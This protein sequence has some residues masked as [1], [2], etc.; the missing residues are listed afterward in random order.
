MAMLLIV[1][2]IP[3]ATIVD[4]IPPTII[5]SAVHPT[6]HV[7]AT[8]IANALLC[9]TWGRIA[10][11]ERV[12]AR[13]G[14]IDRHP[15]RPMRAI[16]KASTPVAGSCMWEGRD[17]WGKVIRTVWLRM[18]SVRGGVVGS[19]FPVLQVTPTAPPSGPCKRLARIGC[20]TQALA[21]V[22]IGVEMVTEAAALVRHKAALNPHAVHLH[23]RRC[24]R[25]WRCLPAIA[26]CPA[27]TVVVVGGAPRSP[28]VDARAPRVCATLVPKRKSAL[29]PMSIATARERHL[30]EW[31]TTLANGIAARYV[32]TAC[33]LML[34]STSVVVLLPSA[35][36]PPP[37]FGAICVARSIVRVETVDEHFATAANK[38]VILVGPRGDVAC[39]GELL[40]AL[41]GGS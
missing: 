33:H 18:C 40:H 29:L 38:T 27:P 4:T 23:R 26:A 6:R 5:A 7:V 39:V 30:V 3:L 9:L 8:M 17:L 20:H 34:D 24:W 41:L 1:M 28:V 12:V 2:P 36:A 14:P 15:R 16:A 13:E 32:L 35:S 11:E 21:R 22:Q 19:D 10:S 37:H 25:R 31:S